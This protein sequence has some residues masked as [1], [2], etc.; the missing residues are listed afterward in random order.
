MEHGKFRWDFPSSND[1]STFKTAFLA[2][3]R[4][5]DVPTAVAFETFGKLGYPFLRSLQ[6][7][8]S[9]PLH[10]SGILRFNLFA[11]ELVATSGQYAKTLS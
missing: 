1:V 9:F 11:L 2:E 3:A 4:W 10:W 5:T 8:S 6:E 7:S